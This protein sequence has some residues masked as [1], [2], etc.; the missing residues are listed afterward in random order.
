MFI[1][2]NIYVYIGPVQLEATTTEV[3]IQPMLN[4]LQPV[5]QPFYSQS[6]SDSERSVTFQFK[7][8]IAK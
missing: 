4:V 2:I 6:R 3:V 5:Q 7:G 8:E 1:L